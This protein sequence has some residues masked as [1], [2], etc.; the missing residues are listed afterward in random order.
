MTVKRIIGNLDH[1][2]WCNYFM[3][4]QKE[5]IRMVRKVLKQSG[6]HNPF[7]TNKTTD[8]ILKRYEKSFW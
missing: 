2:M 3:N 6:M 1:R 4:E 5:S 7:S 8:D